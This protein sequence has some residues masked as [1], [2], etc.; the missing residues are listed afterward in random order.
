[1]VLHYSPGAPTPPLPL[2]RQ[3]QEPQG[4]NSG[5]KHARLPPKA[6]LAANLQNQRARELV[7]FRSEPQQCRGGRRGIHVVQGVLYLLF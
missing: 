7:E 5:Y 1:M 2:H 6:K 4:H 3:N